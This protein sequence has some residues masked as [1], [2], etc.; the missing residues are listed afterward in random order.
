MAFYVIDAG[1]SYVVSA[2]TWDAVNSEW[3]NHGE[4]ISFAVWLVFNMVFAVAL[5]V[6]GRSSRHRL[7]GGLTALLLIVINRASIVPFIAFTDEQLSD[8]PEWPFTA[9]IWINLL[10]FYTAV[11]LGWS[12]ARRRTGFAWLGVIPGVGDRHGDLAGVRRLWPRHRLRGAQCHRLHSHRFR[13]V[14]PRH[15]AGLGVRR[16]RHP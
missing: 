10:S 8:W 13:L 15:P 16:H 7:L 14:R 6:W 12:I 1:L 5:V 4:W 3:I 2:W 9:Q 11:I